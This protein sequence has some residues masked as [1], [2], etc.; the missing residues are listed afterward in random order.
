MSKKKEAENVVEEKKE[1]VEEVKDIK[2]DNKKKKEK[3]EKK[4]NKQEVIKENVTEKAL[5]KKLKRANND[6]IIILSIVIGVLVVAFAIF[7][8]YYYNSSMKAI[9][10]F[11]G[12]KV[13][14]ADYTVYYKTF[15]PM[16][17]YYGYPASIIPE[18][19]ANKAG[20]DMI[21]LN[22]A[23]EKGVTLS[24]DDKAKVDETFNDEEQ[25]QQFIDEGIDVARMKQLYYNDYII[26]AYIDKMT[27]EVA[28]EDVIAYIKSVSGEDADLT[29]YNTS[30]ILFKTI[31]DSGNELS[32]ADQAAKR[33]TAE[34]VLARALNG[35]DFAALAKE[36][37]EDGT[38][39]DGGK[40]TMYMDGS[41]YTEYS[42]AVKTLEVGGITT[43]LVK[44][45]AGYHIIKLDSKVENGRAHNSTEREQ[46]VD[47][48]INNLSTTMHLEINDEAMKA[49]VYAITGTK[50]EDEETDETDE[51]EDTTT[52]DEQ[53]TTDESSTD[54]STTT[55][56]TEAA[57]AE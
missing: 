10:T 18:Q 38:K 57:P 42:D 12:G 52:D 55:D 53:T 3:K 40:F 46:C 21:I 8:V 20:I 13:T 39:D 27:E 51:T 26:S 19:I 35:E 16:L 37:S 5:E 45:D 32:E 14:I 36:F 24:D 7:G 30:H 9:A 25:V 2:Q 6:K 48:Q 49:A 33:A 15:A 29:E 50:V 22:K 43:T 44:S 4:E 23:K 54:D 47:E 56:N 11:D 41:V 28:D 31:D 34:S 17:E 1:V